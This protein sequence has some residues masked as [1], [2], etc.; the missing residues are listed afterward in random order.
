[1]EAVAEREAITRTP[2]PLLLRKAAVLGAG[3]MGSRIAAHLANAGVSVVL[4]DLPSADGARNAVLDEGQA[5]ARLSF[6]VER[7]RD[8]PRV[9]RVLDERDRPGDLLAD[10]PAD[11]LQRGRPPRKRREVV[12]QQ[13]CQGS[14]GEAAVHGPEH[15][16]VHIAR[17]VDVLPHG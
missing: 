1:M 2:T 7:A 9:E 14:G 10:L 4:L 13:H 6:E 15:R 17:S 11:E 8:R 3:T 12:V 16:A 5:V